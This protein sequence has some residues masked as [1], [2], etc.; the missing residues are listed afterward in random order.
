MRVAGGG[1]GGGDPVQG[2]PNGTGVFVSHQLGASS[3]SPSQG[4]GKKSMGQV[5][6]T[7][8]GQ[9]GGGCTKKPTQSQNREKQN[10]KKKQKNQSKRGNQNGRGGD[11]NPKGPPTA[12]TPLKMLTKKKNKRSRNKKGKKRRKFKKTCCNTTPIDSNHFAS[13][14]LE[15]RAYGEGPYF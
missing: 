7:D 2:A 1:G 14:A 3:N 8:W 10:V 11:R 4:G 13:A 5:S 15:T 12:V 6:P 9:R